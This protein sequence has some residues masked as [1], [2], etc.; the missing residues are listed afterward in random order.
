MDPGAGSLRRAPQYSKQ[1]SNRRSKGA[2]ASE[3]REKEETEQEVAAVLQ[4]SWWRKHLMLQVGC[5]GG[6]VAEQ[7]SPA[8]FNCFS[9]ISASL[10]C[11]PAPVE[12]SSC[13]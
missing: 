5:W 9:T 6:W 7:R 1:S 10:L 4:G 3:E 13:F 2:D 11:N 8:C 12:S